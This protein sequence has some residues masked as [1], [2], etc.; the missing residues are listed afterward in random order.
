MEERQIPFSFAQLEYFVA[1]AE[2]G[3]IS[4]A[5]AKLHASQSALSSALL[6]LERLLGTQLL[7]RNHARGVRLTQ[8]GEELLI[9]ARDVLS[10]AHLLEQ[11]S[12]DLQGGIRGTLNAGCFLTI[13]PFVIPPVV[14]E[15][16]R[17]HPDLDLRV[18]ELDTPAIGTALQ[19]G[20]IEVAVC[21]R[22]GLGESTTFTE[23]A[24][25]RPY[26]LVS[27]TSPLAGRDAVSLAELA[28]EPLVVLRLPYVQNRTLEFFRQSGHE[29]ARVIETSSFETMRGLVSAGA[30]V[31]VLNQR[32]GTDH[33]YDGGRV[34]SVELSDPVAPASVGIA[35]ARGARVTERARVFSAACARAIRAS[36]R[37]SARSRADDNADDGA[38][39]PNAE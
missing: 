27:P 1:V 25:L 3:N 22:I 31:T 39:E 15:L 17:D 38:D 26:A 36:I 23:L 19:E 18:T 35:T 10:R 28:A 34:V 9:H 7:I 32:V 29:P 13:A 37:A 16:R 14:R 24:T 12:V 21:Y 8:H 5:A 11:T 4:A 33:T 20:R 6:R 30:G 2:T